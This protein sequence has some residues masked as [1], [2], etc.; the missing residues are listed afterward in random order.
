MDV[1]HRPR[2]PEA[3][4]AEL[5]SHRSAHLRPDQA[6]ADLVAV[7]V[8]GFP[9]LRTLELYLPFVSEDAAGI[10]EPEEK[11]PKRRA[12]TDKAAGKNIPATPH[13]TA[14]TAKGLFQH[15]R[16][17]STR[18]PSCLSKL[19]VAIAGPTRYYDSF[20]KRAR[21]MRDHEIAFACVLSARDD[22]AA[23]R[24]VFTTTCAGLPKVENE[25]IRAALDAAA[26]GHHPLDLLGSPEGD[27]DD[28]CEIV[29]PGFKYAWDGPL[30]MKERSAYRRGAV[31]AHGRYAP[32]AGV[33]IVL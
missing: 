24:S 28:D 31:R 11:K 7:I 16:S 12:P 25:A 26:A 3:H 5:S 4:P 32:V 8:A 33:D 18:Q 2:R 21:W 23:A 30:T 10:Y 15:P 22:E 14:R 27:D 19:T 20:S 6:Q 9:K 17:T 29:S 1:A 13:L